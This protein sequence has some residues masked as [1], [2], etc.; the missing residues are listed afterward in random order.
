[1]KVV[2]I[3]SYSNSL[4]G[5]PKSMISLMEC[6]KERYDCEL[7]TLTEG[8]VVDE[9][10]RLGFNVNIS[11]GNS[12]LTDSSKYKGNIILFCYYVVLHWVG[13]F[14]FFKNKKFDIIYIN[15][16]RAFLYYLPYIILN[17][18]KS[19]YYTRINAK[20]PIINSL[21][22][23]F[24]KKVFLISND[25]KNAF[26]RY[27][28]NLFSHKV[29]V[30]HTGFNFDDTQV[31]KVDLET[32][33]IC[34]IGTLCQRKNQLMLLESIVKFIDCNPKI[35]IEIHLFSNYDEDDAYTKELIKFINRNELN[36]IVF[37]RGYSNDIYSEIRDFDILVSSSILEGLPR[38]CIEALS[39]GL[40]VI[41]TNIDGV[42][43]IIQNDDLG[44]IVSENNAEKI[45]D[46][47]EYYI[48]NRAKLSSFLSRKNRSDFCRGQFSITKF[49]SGFIDVLESL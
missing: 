46:S 40:Y 48:N 30:L 14:R 36:E 32:L 17:H 4:G 5:A 28:Y 37:F 20:L 42:K 19:V 47:L 10:K 21:I 6:V 26:N 1:M 22:L 27:F 31:K 29:S 9:S 45:S 25:T 7:L 41:S 39:Q 8:S 16:P 38:V 2:F 43:D 44:V 23:F 3:D 34:N 11:N 18:K 35:A 13:L 15:E 12:L 24:V 49:K 33:R